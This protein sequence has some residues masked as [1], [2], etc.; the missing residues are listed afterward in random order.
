MDKTPLFYS[1]VVPINMFEQVL[2][3]KRKEDGIFTTPAGGANPGELPEDCAVRECFEE[4]GLLIDKDRLELIKVK[5]APNGKPVHCFL[6]RTNQTNLHV[7]HDPDQE[8]ENWEWK[9]AF[10]LPDELRRK[11]NVNRL[12]TINEAFMK[13]FG[14][15]KAKKFPIGTIRYGRKKVD[16]GK[17]VPVKKNKL[18]REKFIPESKNY[19]IGT[20]HDF[21]HGRYAKIA[22]GWLRK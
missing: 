22:G 12:E 3:G 1:A 17:W 14:L 7:G 6:Y 4:A 19:E 18:N 20:V 21:K 13:Y 2:I 8:V 10:D 11:N 16:E 5:T 9:H 15:T